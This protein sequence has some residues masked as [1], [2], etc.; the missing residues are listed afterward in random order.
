LDELSLQLFVDNAKSVSLSVCI[1][2]A[3][4]LLL[5]RDSELL[6]LGFSQS[7]FFKV[8]SQTAVDLIGRLLLTRLLIDL[9]PHAFNLFGELFYH[10][11]VLSALVS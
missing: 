10:P 5:K 6:M 11:I 7:H 2:P 8:A 3:L 4:R 1:D 9:E